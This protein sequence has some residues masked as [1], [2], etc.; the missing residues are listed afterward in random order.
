MPYLISN[1]IEKKYTPSFAR[2]A[3]KHLTR[4]PTLGKQVRVAD[5][6]FAF[7]KTTPKNHINWKQLCI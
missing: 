1:L 2:I 7:R 6:K 4:K 5:V 3:P